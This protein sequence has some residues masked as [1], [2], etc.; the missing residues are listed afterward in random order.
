V[1]L[2]STGEE[3]QGLTRKES[4]ILTRGR[5]LQLPSTR[6]GIWW[7]EEKRCSI[8]EGKEGSPK[9]RKRRRGFEAPRRRRVLQCLTK[10]ASYSYKEGKSSLTTAG[11]KAEKL[12]EEVKR[13][14]IEGRGP[15]SP[16]WGKKGRKGVRGRNLVGRKGDKA[17][18]P[19][20]KGKGYG[21][22][23]SLFKRGIHWNFQEEEKKGDFFVN[24]KGKKKIRT[25]EKGGEE[26]GSLD[27][28]RVRGEGGKETK[29]KTRTT[30]F[31]GERLFLGGTGVLKKGG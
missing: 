4:P 28:K 29:K 5:D 20:K 27:Y 11:E 12:R 9:P 14:Y 8:S 6:E 1:R 15:F 26:E 21:K 18:F 7:K 23:S 30:F 2:Y 31:W 16:F 22:Q 3:E 19:K 17:S 25:I 10:E 13:S 24:Q